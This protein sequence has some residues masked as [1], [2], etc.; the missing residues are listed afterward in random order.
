M[1]QLAH[2]E[3]FLLL[4]LVLLLL[5]RGFWPRLEVGL[6]RTL[7]LLCALLLLA[8]PF[9]AGDTQGRDVLLLVDRSLSMPVATAA[10]VEELAGQL[11]ERMQPGDRI[12]LI[13]FGRAPVLEAAQSEAFQFRP[14]QRPV[15]PDATDLGA[16]EFGVGR[17]QIVHIGA[18]DLAD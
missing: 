15:D 12:G 8:R 3:A 7:L 4:P 1:I 13:A 18:I 10:R 14:P 9:A 16:A 6:L 17:E 5:R 2:P 11:S